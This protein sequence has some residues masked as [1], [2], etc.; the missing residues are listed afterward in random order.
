MA[1]GQWLQRRWYERASPWRT[2]AGLAFLLLPLQF[3]FV[4][5]SSLRRHAYCR[6]WLR[7]TRLQ[8]PVVVVGNITVGGAGKTPLTL[9]LVEALRAQGY[10]PGIISRGYGGRVAGI[11]AVPVNG[12]P[13]NFGD[14]PVLLARRSGVPVY[15]GAHRAEA[16]RQLLADHPDID[17]L[18]CDDGLQHYALARDAEIVV[19][20]ARAW[21]NGWRLPLGPLREPLPR[22]RAAQ[23]VV[24]NGGEVA[25]L[26]SALPGVPVFSMSLQAERFVSLQNAAVNCGPEDLQKQPLFAAA[27]IGHPERFFQTL[28]DMQLPITARAFS[29]HHAYQTEDLEFARQGVLL[30][31]EKDGVKCAPLYDGPAWV[32][33]VT[34]RLPSALADLIV[35]KIRGRQAP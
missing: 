24:S 23:A 11:A 15:V 21:G 32:L 3:L 17:L 9:W 28:L 25:A 13:A 22:A 34:A 14:E 26:Q 33:P 1:L 7:S 30:L 5:L 29:D 27:G 2:M 8:V 10:R 31:T 12:D 6:G 16:G 19:F 18:V 4:L 20:D 35:E